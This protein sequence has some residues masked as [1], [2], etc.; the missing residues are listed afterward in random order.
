MILTNYILS[1]LLARDIPSSPKYRE[2]LHTLLHKEHNKAIIE[3]IYNVGLKEHQ[4]TPNLDL[5]SIFTIDFCLQHA[6]D[7]LAYLQNDHEIIDDF[8]FHSTR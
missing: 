8:N 2:L 5:I 4:K 6:Y 1:R 7:Y 3:Y